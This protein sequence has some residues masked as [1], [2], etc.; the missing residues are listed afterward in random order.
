MLELLRAEDEEG[1]VPKVVVH[2]GHP[3]GLQRLVHARGGRVDDGVDAELVRVLPHSAGDSVDSVDITGKA[4]NETSRKSI[5]T[6]GVNRNCT[7]V[8]VNFSVP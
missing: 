7:L 4:I 5:S 3:G 8:F 2:G 1:V 6:L